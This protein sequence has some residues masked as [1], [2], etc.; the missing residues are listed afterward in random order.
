MSPASGRPVSD[1]AA[2]GAEWTEHDGVLERTPYRSNAGGGMPVV[3]Y[4]HGRGQTPRTVSHVEQA[5]A[6]ARVI[7]PT[8]G[9][10]LARG[11]TWF[12]NRQIGV[13]EPQSLIEAECRFLIWMALHLG[14][15]VRP[16]LCGFSN[17]GAF[18]AHLLIH[19]PGRFSGAAL[20]S[21][22]IVLPPWPDGALAKKPV[23]YARGTRDNVVPIASFEQAETYLTASSG[24]EITLGRYKIAHEIAEPEI[25]DLGFWF[26]RRTAPVIS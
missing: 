15:T 3:I 22:P 26:E 14:E 11:T 12:E 23:F 6:E 2:S 1:I 24:G 13:A 25:V 17:G 5:F 21:A 16:W 18:A 20:L 8:G 7:A 10:P 19:N 4:F 9:V